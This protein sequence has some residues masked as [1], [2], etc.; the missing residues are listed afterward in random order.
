MIKIVIFI[1]LPNILKGRNLLVN[2]NS[3]NYFTYLFIMTYTIKAVIE[4]GWRGGSEYS[5]IF[6]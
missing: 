4:L 3:G 2:F 6:H 1:Y 5:L